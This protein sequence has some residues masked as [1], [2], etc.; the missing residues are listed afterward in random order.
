MN[1]LVVLC[2][3]SMILLMLCTTGYSQGIVGS[4]HDFTSEA[5]ATEVCAVCHTPHDAK[6][7]ITN[8]PLWNHEST[9]A[10]FTAYTS[11]TMNAA[12]GQPDGISKLCLSCHD[13]TVALDNY[14]GTT[15][16]TNLATGGALVGTDLSNDH[17]ISFTYNAALSS[18]DNG[19]HDPTSTNSGLG[20]TITDDLLFGD[21]LE[22]ASCHDVHN[23]VGGTSF[24][25]RIDNTSSALCL[26]CHNK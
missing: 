23:S 13:G 3:T 7:G 26:K 5:W 24:L 1:R 6:T 18:A 16:G 11:T 22:C 2:C 12:V 20:S 4:K 25:L 21:K 9:S 19:L 10:T 15:N 14:G 17:P 8:A